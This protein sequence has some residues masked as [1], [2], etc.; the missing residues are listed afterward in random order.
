VRNKE[1]AE[2]SVIGILGIRYCNVFSHLVNNIPW[3]GASLPSFLVSFAAQQ[4]LV[5]L[6]R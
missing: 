2:T 4:V 6:T 5:R 1:K 3:L